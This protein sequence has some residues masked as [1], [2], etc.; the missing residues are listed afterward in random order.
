MLLIYILSTVLIVGFV[1]AAL[2]PERARWVLESLGLWEWVQA[3]DGATLHRWIRWL[4]QFLLLSAA[5]LSGAILAGYYT[6]FWFVPA[7]QAALFG[8]ILW[9][10]GKPSSK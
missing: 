3:I 6:N 10:L 9:W 2:L 7:A 4:G 1:L 5:V 8:G